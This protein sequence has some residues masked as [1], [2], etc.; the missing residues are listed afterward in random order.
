[1]LR[2][3]FIGFGEPQGLEF[4]ELPKDVPLT[5][6][7][8]GLDVCLEVCAQQLFVLQ[9]YVRAMSFTLYIH[10]HR[11]FK[12]AHRTLWQSLMMDQTSLLKL[13]DGFHFSLEGILSLV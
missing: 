4:T 1:M 8:V 10:T 12:L 13:R 2:Q 5:E 11:P 9:R 7:C 3:A 6:V